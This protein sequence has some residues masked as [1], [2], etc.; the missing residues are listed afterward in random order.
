M[1]SPRH[2]L[3]YTS[4]TLPPPLAYAPDTLV[5]HIAPAPPQY[6]T[7]ALHVLPAA[8]LTYP[9]YPLHILPSPILAFLFNYSYI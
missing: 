3:V 5:R 4:P 7:P 6:P 2:R 9:L 1:L 8:A